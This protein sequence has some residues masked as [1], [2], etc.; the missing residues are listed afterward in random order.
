MV[1]R[2]TRMWRAIALLIAVCALP[3]AGCTAQAHA[4]FLS[5]SPGGS[6]AYLLHLPGIAGERWLDQEMVR[7]VR[8]G[9]F[10]GT[11]EIYDWTHNDPGVGALLAQERNRRESK[12]IADLIESRFRADPS[13]KI[14][15]TC[16]SGGAGLAVWA[17]ERLPNDV[18]ID[19]LFL[20][21]PALSQ[22]Y[23]LS[24]ALAHVTNRA[25]VFT[26]VNDVIVLGMG[27]RLFGTIDGVKEEAAGMRGFHRPAGA[28]AAQYKKLAQF[29]YDER[30]V[31][32]D[33]IGD[34]IGNMSKAFA[35][36]VV[37]PLATGKKP[38]LMPRELRASTRPATEPARS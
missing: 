38:S 23:D 19:T 15:I 35:K 13:A 18:Q 21:S 8:E 32:L 20:L 31:D 16:H 12:K 29:P 34:H 27:T 6:S 2:S 22:R 7:G 30:W 5:A 4:R 37:A 14:T 1:Y 33:N 28:D 26:S 10:D 9:G 3:S 36:G 25:Y 24:K 17:L 11:L